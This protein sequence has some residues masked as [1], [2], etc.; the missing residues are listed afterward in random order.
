MLAGS[1][2]LFVYGSLCS[3][4]GHPMAARL[5]AAAKLIGAGRFQGC[6]YRIDWY[7]GAVASDH[8]DDG[9]DGE[10]YRMDAPELTLPLLD[11]YEETGPGFAE[12]AEFRRELQPVR[13]ETGETLQCWLYLYNRPLDGKPQIRPESPLIAAGIPP[14]KTEM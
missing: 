4:S 2:L 13:L 1:D 3:G 6:L 5:A 10:V 9:I 14:V 8:A 12:P 11:A 7:P